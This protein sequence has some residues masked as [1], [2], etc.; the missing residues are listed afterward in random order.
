MPRRPSGM[1][2]VVHIVPLADLF[3]C[4]QCLE[5]APREDVPKLRS[6]L[7]GHRKKDQALRYRHSEKRR[8]SCRSQSVLAE[9]VE[10]DF[11]RLVNTLQVDHHAIQLMAE[12]AVEAGFGSLA[13][14]DKA[15]LEA[16]KE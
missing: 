5:D 11:S 13:D 4:A 1:I 3:F 12:L 2:H 10:Q 16:Q 8:C 9:E 15:N 7:I 14:E 6:R